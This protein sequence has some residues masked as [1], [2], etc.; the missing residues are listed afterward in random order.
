MLQRKGKSC[1]G[2]WRTTELWKIFWRKW[3]SYEGLLN[4]G[5][6]L[7]E[8]EGVMKDY[9]IMENIPRGNYWILKDYWIIDEIEEWNTEAWRI[10]ELSMIFKRNVNNDEGLLNHGRY[11]KEEQII[12]IIELEWMFQ[13]R[14]DSYEALWKIIELRKIFQRTIN[15]YEGFLNYGR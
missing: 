1:E 2:L 8:T 12:T 14:G 10:I 3:N 6:F 13:R 11:F 4:D 7:K 15:I 9:W 5:R